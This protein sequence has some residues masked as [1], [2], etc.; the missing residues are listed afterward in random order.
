MQSANVVLLQNDPKT[1][2]SLVKF[3]CSSFH[4][5]YPVRSLVELRTNIA[6]HRA[7]VVILDMELASIE[8][9]E[10]LAQEFPGTCIICTHRLADEE[11]WTAAL[12]AGAADIV[13]AGD[14][15]GI[16]SAAQR[17]AA[18]SPSFAA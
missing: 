13:S 7:Q 8:D 17:T 2:Q 10:R 12:N 3:L 16:L 5:I 9:V 11:M 1:S 15:R 18:M 14:C 4:S 6:K